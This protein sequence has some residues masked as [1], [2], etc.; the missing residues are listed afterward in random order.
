MPTRHADAIWKGSLKEGTGTVKV[1]SGLLDTAYNFVSRFETG[2][3]TNPEE[4]LGASHAGC[5]A[6]FLAAL[7]SGDDFTVNEVKARADVTVDSTDDGPTITEIT[8][9][10]TGNV[11]NIDEAAFLGYAEKAKAKCPIS[12]ALAS[13]ATI[14]LNATL[15]S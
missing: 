14:N 5:Y 13:V 10:V 11:S 15:V 2:D 3:Q 9:T 8:L 12:K 1:E 6:M 4:L 7:L